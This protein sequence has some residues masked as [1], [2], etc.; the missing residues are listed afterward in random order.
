M[1]FIFT[2][3]NEVAK[4]MF[5]HVSVILFTGGSAVGGGCSRGVCSRVCLLRGSLRPGGACSSGACSRGVWRPPQ[6]RRLLLRT[7]HILLECI[8]VAEIN[9]HLFQ[10]GLVLSLGYVY[11]TIRITEVFS[12]PKASSFCNVQRNVASLPF[13]SKLNSN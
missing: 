3:R 9:F 10:S 8:L 4:V 5:L 7:V 12:L 6:S 11:L 1:F 2:V 13:C